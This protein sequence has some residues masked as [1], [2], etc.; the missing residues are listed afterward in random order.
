[1]YQPTTPL[2]FSTDVGVGARS[3][4]DYLYSNGAHIRRSDGLRLWR[5]SPQSSQEIRLIGEDVDGVFHGRIT[6]KLLVERIKRYWDE[7]FGVRYTNCSSFANYLTTG[8]FVECEVEKGLLVIEQGMRPYEMAS[9][10][11]V[12]DMVCLFYADDQRARSRANPYAK[13]YRQAK[14]RQYDGEGFAGAVAMELKSRS[15]SPD[16]IRLMHSWSWV[17]DFHFMV[18]VAKWRN[19]PI[20]ISQVGRV[21]PGEEQV[22]FSLTRGVKD[23]YGPEVPVFALIKKRR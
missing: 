2:L 4:R 11:D 14:K 22:M 7:Y 15:F 18:C 1:M 23:T 20:W 21:A 19:Q 10:V 17:R 8:V 3:I 9:R 16:E 5:A 13:R 6:D 12:G